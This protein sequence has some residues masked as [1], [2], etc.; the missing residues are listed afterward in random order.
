MSSSRI[1][2]ISCLTLKTVRIVFYFLL[3]LAANVIWDALLLF[4]MLRLLGPSSAAMS[5]LSFPFFWLFPLVG[6]LVVL[7]RNEAL[8]SLPRILRAL[9]LCVVAFSAAELGLTVA[10]RCISVAT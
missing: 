2:Q 9:T 10:V 4:G 7:Y 6:Y 5:Y 1:V 8:V 3:L